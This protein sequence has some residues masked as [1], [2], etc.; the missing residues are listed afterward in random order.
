MIDWNGRVELEGRPGVS[1]GLYPF[2]S[3]TACSSVL[4][5]R[6]GGINGATGKGAHNPK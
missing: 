2:N 6:F 1:A 5:E 4:V 3:L